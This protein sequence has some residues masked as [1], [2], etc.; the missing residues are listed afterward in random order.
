MGFILPKQF[1]WG[2]ELS[3]DIKYKV[4]CISILKPLFLNKPK[5]DP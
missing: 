2:K 3:Y 5:I 4:I 1:I